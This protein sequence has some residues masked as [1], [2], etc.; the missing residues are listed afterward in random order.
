MQADR[1]LLTALLRNLVLN[2]A[3]AGPND[4]TVGGRRGRSP[5]GDGL[6]VEDQGR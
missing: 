1:V 4:E 2:A 6:S 5:H 3:A